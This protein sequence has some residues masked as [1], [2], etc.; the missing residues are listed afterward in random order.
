MKAVSRKWSDTGWLSV[1]ERP[2]QLTERDVRLAFLSCDD[3]NDFPLSMRYD[4]GQLCTF[5]RKEKRDDRQ[6]R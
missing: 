1:G 2:P 6:T 4:N 5:K 3:L